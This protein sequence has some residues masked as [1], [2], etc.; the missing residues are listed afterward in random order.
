[1]VLQADPDRSV[2]ALSHGMG[3]AFSYWDRDLTPPL[4]PIVLK[5]ARLFAGRPSA[6]FDAVLAFLRSTLP[7][8]AEFRLHRRLIAGQTMPRWPNALRGGPPPPLTR[9]LW[10]FDPE[11]AGLLAGTRQLVKRD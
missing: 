10:P 1:V 9:S 3:H 5:T 6:D 8:D 2:R 4:R 11:V 7:A